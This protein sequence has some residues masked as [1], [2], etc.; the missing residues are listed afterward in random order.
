M[1]K[2]I[3]YMCKRCGE[4]FHP[5]DVVELYVDGKLVRRCPNCG[6][7]SMRR[8]VINRRRLREVFI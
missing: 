5:D 7:Y 2:L 6:C 8:I 4:R 1:P 3:V